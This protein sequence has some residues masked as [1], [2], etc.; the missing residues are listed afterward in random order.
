MKVLR[1]KT[2]SEVTTEC[3][4]LNVL[5]WNSFSLSYPSSQFSEPS[6]PPSLSLAWT[7]LTGLLV[8]SRLSETETWQRYAWDPDNTSW[9]LTLITLWVRGETHRHSKRTQEII[10]LS[11][12]SRLWCSFCGS[13][14][15]DKDVMMKPWRPDSMSETSRGGMTPAS[16][17]QEKIKKAWPS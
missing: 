15:P 5:L 3:A 8:Q 6:L 1:S 11:S 4:Y 10:V 12:V 2:L 9:L 14:S 16:I 17:S 7:L 13:S